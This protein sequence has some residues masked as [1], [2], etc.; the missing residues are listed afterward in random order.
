MRSFAFSLF[1]ATAIAAP[2]LQAAPPNAQWYTLQTKAFVKNPT[3]PETEDRKG[4]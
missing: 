2:A 1:F 4:F 3:H